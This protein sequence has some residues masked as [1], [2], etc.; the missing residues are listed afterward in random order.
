VPIRQV[1]QQ[2]A[3]NKA[4]VVGPVWIF[5]FIFFS[6]LNWFAQFFIFFFSFDF[7]FYNSGG[8]PVFYGQRKLFKFERWLNLFIWV[9]RPAMTNRYIYRALAYVYVYIRC[10]QYVIRNKWA[11]SRYRERVLVHFKWSDSLSSSQNFLSK[12]FTHCLILLG[13]RLLI[14]QCRWICK[15]S[16]PLYYTHRVSIWKMCG[17][18][19]TKKNNN[20]H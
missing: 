13:R 5:F 18:T 4:K 15:Q 6:I 14:S 17:K 9:T 19:K 20:F 10:A 2:W 8:T 7:L 11:A 12:H 3:S 1:K 16:R